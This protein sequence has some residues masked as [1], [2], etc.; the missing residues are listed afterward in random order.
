MFKTYDNTKNK[1]VW[2]LWVVLLVEFFGTLIMVFEILAPSAFRLGDNHIYGIIFGSNIMKAM[3]VS[4]FIYGLI[5]L[6][7]RISVN[8][9][10]A[11]TLAEIAAGNTTV[12]RGGMMIVAQ[13]FVALLAGEFSFLIADAIGTWHGDGTDSLDALAPR[14]TFNGGFMSLLNID[15]TLVTSWAEVA[16]TG[17]GWLYGIVPFLIEF[18]LVYALIASII[19]GK[20]G[21]M[22]N[23]KPIVIFLTLT[24]VVTLGIP[25]DSFALNPA[26][27]YGAAIATQING[28]EKTLEYAWIYLAGELLAVYVFFVVEN[29]R[30]ERQGNSKNSLQGELKSSFSELLVVKAKYEWVL[31]DNKP[32]DK[33]NKMELLSASKKEGIDIS[34]T[35]SRDDIEYELI[36]Y[37]IF[38]KEEVKKVEDIKEVKE[39][40]PDNND[41]DDQSDILGEPTSEEKINSPLKKIKLNIKDKLKK[42]SK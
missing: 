28:G 9:N 16:P 39:T 23:T 31:K 33:M 13:V 5:L 4:L 1:L 38:G 6:F 25:T 12:E 8:L 10:P 7:R 29:I 41:I 30:K 14:L 32:L 34:K 36:E 24:A 2:R 3:W 26:R 18:V 40:K 19:Y 21:I 17:Y 20:N 42:K 27:L 15:S 37:L 35:K 22:S 11:V